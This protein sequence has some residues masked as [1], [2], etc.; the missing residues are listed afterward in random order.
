MK[1]KSCS[2]RLLA[3]LLQRLV[4]KMVKLRGSAHSLLVRRSRESISPN[5]MTK[6][7]RCLKK[8]LKIGRL[9]TT[10]LV[11]KIG[12]SKESLL[13]KEWTTTLFYLLKKA[14]WSGLSRLVWVAK[15]VG[16]DQRIGNSVPR[17]VQSPVVMVRIQKTDLKSEPKVSLRMTLTI[18]ANLMRE[19]LNL[20]LTRMICCLRQCRVHLILFYH[21]TL[22]M[23]LQI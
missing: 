2:L 17:R 13:T 7:K 23:N 22:V 9:A 4:K 1:C 6:T 20:P 16:Q 19:D 11:K 18:P 3:L 14:V 15:W 5:M 21:Q 12:V 8:H 10:D